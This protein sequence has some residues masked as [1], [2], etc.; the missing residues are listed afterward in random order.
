MSLETFDHIPA[1]KELLRGSGLPGLTYYFVRT[2]NLGQAQTDGLMHTD[3]SDAFR[4]NGPKGS[5][6]CLLMC[7]GE[8]I[9]GASSHASKQHVLVDED[10]YKATGLEK[11]EENP[12]ASESL[13]P[14]DHPRPSTSL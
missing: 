11:P 4:I 3:K 7:S 14:S 5:S 12:P 10:I 13:P 1:L 9:P 2:S 6:D 8:R